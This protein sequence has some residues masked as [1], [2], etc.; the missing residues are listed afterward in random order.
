MKKRCIAIIAMFLMVSFSYAQPGAAKP[1]DENVEE[2][3]VNHTV[4]MGETVVM[5]AKKYKVTPQDLYEYNPAAV[6]GLSVNMALK[7]PMHRTVDMTHP[8][9]NEEKLETKV[10]DTDIA[11]TSNKPSKPEP[12][13]AEMQNAA[14]VPGVASAVQIADKQQVQGSPATP[15]KAS[16]VPGAPGTKSHIV[17]EGETLFQIAYKNNIS[18]DLL[19]QDNRDVLANNG[20]KPGITLVVQQGRELFATPLEPI[21]DEVA[22]TPTIVT[23]HVVS[24][25]TLHGLSR[26][27]HTTIEDITA[28]NPKALKRG[29][30]MGQTLKIPSNSA[31]ATT[32]TAVDTAV[33][34]T[35][36][37]T[38]ATGGTPVS[39]KYIATVPAPVTTAVAP[40]A[41]ET[42]LAATTADAPAELTGTASIAERLDVEHK[43]KSGDTLTGLA[44]KYNTTIEAITEANKAKLKHGL[45]AG[46]VI[47]ITSNT[48]SN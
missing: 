38:P 33:A 31:K 36:T 9:K 13:L 15:G 2:I 34:V 1:A 29:L 8:K 5:V 10:K 3:I 27:Y 7:I 12:R 40:V 30:Q 14:Q 24:G 39:S 32:S 37:E 21:A 42:A 44:R 45:Q 25:E 19:E 22:A 16:L 43:V 20:F 17:Q 47:K 11:S 35:P 6:D 46:Q 28:A 4:T 48:S 18:Q 26:K 41:A 23:H